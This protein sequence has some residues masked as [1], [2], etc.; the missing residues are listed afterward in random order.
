MR[1][2]PRKG[3]NSPKLLRRL[4]TG[5]ISSGLSLRIDKSGGSVHFSA[6]FNIVDMRCCQRKLII[7]RYGKNIAKLESRKEN[8]KM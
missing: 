7:L 1:I 3:Y 6:P 2:G 5:H 4:K 8:R